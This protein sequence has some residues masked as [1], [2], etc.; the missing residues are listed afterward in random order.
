MRVCLFVSFID[1]LCA[2]VFVCLSECMVARLSV[3]FACVCVRSFVGV[4]FV[5]LIV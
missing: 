3:L 4:C 1:C 5:C 2:R